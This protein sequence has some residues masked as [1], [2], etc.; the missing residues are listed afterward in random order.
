MTSDWWGPCADVECLEAH[1][2]GR[3][4]GGLHGLE[5][6]R[7]VVRVELGEVVVPVRGSGAD[8]DTEVFDELMSRL[9]VHKIR[10]MNAVRIG[11]G[12]T[13]EYMIC[14]AT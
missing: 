2:R 7:R 1:G 13:D 12:K 6:P 11:A 14:R 4:E 5:H 3:G 8:S 9:A 10:V